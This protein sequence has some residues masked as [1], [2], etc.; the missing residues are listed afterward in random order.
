MSEAWLPA[1]ILPAMHREFPCGYTAQSQPC[2]YP[3]H[4]YF[5]SPINTLPTCTYFIPAYRIAN[6]PRP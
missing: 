6:R 1:S 4:R 2:T 3:A 5:Q